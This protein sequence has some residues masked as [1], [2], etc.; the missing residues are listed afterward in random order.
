MSTIES[1]RPAAPGPTLDISQTAPV[2]FSRLVRVEWRKMVDTRSGF[3]LMIATGILLVLTVA[4]VLLVVGLTED[5][6][7]IGAD[8]FSQI[9]TIP[10]SLL[11]PVFPILAVTSE[12]SQRTGLV[13]F[14]LE[15]HRVRVLL[16]K[17]GAV[18]LL[19][20]AT[21]VVALVLGAVGNVVAAAMDGNS[22]KW[23]LDLEML[24]LTIL[25]QLL[26]FLMAYAFGTVLL[27]TPASIAV[28]YVVA[29]LLPL[30]VY[31]TLYAIFD[32][33]QD[34]IPWIDMQY[35]MTPF[36]DPDDTATAMDGL[37][38]L[39]TVLIWVVTPLVIGTRRV[40]ASE[41]K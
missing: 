16:A 15:P 35:A 37:R 29:L 28:F 1:G 41:P 5:D 19:A 40:L 20:V 14:A 33:A 31:S 2:P 12:W 25:S 3:W 6:L 9:L 30:L 21:I 17:V 18:V 22:P 11:L 10:L 39:V 32:W 13:T 36:L 27:N 23:N 26:Y 4:L 8:G 24:A 34:L 38:L 7:T